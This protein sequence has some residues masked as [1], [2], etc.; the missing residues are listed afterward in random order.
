MRHRMTRFTFCI[1]LL[2]LVPSVYSQTC[3]GKTPLDSMEAQVT[4]IFEQ[5][6]DA[7]VRIH[8]NADP[9]KI[10]RRPDLPSY[11]VGSG[12]IMDKAGRIATTA[13]NV[14]DADQV[15]IEWK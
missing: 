2:L 12:F 13:S 15:Q 11:R 5:S 14:D 9:N 7:V 6:R 4:R 8:A 3:G 10:R 1:C